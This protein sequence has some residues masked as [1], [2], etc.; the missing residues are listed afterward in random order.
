SA[1]NT[2]LKRAIVHLEHVK[3]VTAD[4]SGE[5]SLQASTLVGV[6]KSAEFESFDH[7]CEALEKGRTPAEKGWRE[8]LPDLAHRLAETRSPLFELSRQAA[9][10]ESTRPPHSTRTTL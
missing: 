5:L 1:A 2:A 3:S 7:L 6:L 10:F 4:A 8:S 9:R